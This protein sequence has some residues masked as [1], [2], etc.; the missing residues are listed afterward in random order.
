MAA[1]PVLRDLPSSRCLFNPNL[2]Q[3]TLLISIRMRLG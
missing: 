3:L 2:A 1:N